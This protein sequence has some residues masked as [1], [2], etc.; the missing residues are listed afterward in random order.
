VLT[1]DANIWIA[2]YDPNDRFHTPSVRFLFAVTRQGQTFNGPAFVLVEAGC[3]LARRAQNAA[4]GQE[5]LERLRLHPLLTLQPLND[6]LL[7]SASQLG[8]QYLLRGADALYAA[9]AQL[10][11][12]QLISWDEELIHRANALTPSDWLTISSSLT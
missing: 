3:A 8:I 7:A 1:L 11:N 9:T 12:A 6:A 10:T 2:A 4:V 5:A